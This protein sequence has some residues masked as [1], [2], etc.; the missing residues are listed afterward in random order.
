[1][2]LQRAIQLFPEFGSAYYALALSYRALGRVEDA[3]GALARHAQFGSRWPAV[4]D[5]VRAALSTIRD[6]AEANLQRGINRAEA[7]DLAGAIAAHE[8][9]LARDASL[10]K[11]HANLITLYGQRG[12][13]AKAGEHYRAVQAL[14]AASSSAHYDYGVLL[15]MQEQW[16]LAAD[17]YRRAL[18]IDDGHVQ[19]RNNLGQVLERQQ[20]FEAAV[21]QYR[22][23]VMRQPSFRLAR[24]N[25]GRALLLLGRNDEAIAELTTLAQPE[26]PTPPA[27]CLR[28]PPHTFAPG[29]ETRG[30]SGGSRPGALR[31]RT[32]SRSS[33]QSSTG[34]SPG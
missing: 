25:L 23:A 15:G 19:A 1:M 21:D 4:D 17:A 5:P 32:D 9:A 31:L 7:G 27:T 3:R 6:D 26:T 20:Q 29:T 34:I 14:G 12:D 22:Q 30:S 16:D 24:F 10:A 11:A 33:Q 2:H 18:D 28:C 8:A 13:F